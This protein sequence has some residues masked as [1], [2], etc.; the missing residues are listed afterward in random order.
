MDVPVDDPPCHVWQ[1]QRDFES[2]AS[3]TALYSAISGLVT[4][5]TALRWGYL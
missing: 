2:N 4:L 5:K 1:K 3:A